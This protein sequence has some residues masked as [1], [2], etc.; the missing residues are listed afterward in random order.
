MK[1]ITDKLILIIFCCIFCGRTT[2]EII[3]ILVATALSALFQYTDSK[4][5]TF[6]AGLLYIIMCTVFPSFALALPPIIYDLYNYKLFPH[7]AIAGGI[8]VFILASD[9][10]LIPIPILMIYTI[11]VY[12]AHRTSTF[13]NLFKSYIS[14]VDHSTEVTRH[15]KENNLRL[16]ESKNYEVHLAT[17][18]ERNRIAREIHDNVGHLLSRSILHVQA[19]KL[20]NDENVRKDG[21]NDL[22][23]TLGSAMD[24]IRQSVHNLHDNSLELDYAIREAVEPLYEKGF[25]VEYQCCCSENVPVRVRLSLISIVKESV[26]N[27]IKHS[28]GNRAS[29]IFTEHPAFWQLK[30]EDNGSCSKDI[31]E[32]GIGIFNMRTRIEELGGIFNINSDKNGFRIFISIRKD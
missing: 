15:L 6:A 8:T 3:A 4:K 2:P 24:S 1:K 20:I 27:I 19:L 30:I 23:G 7:I 10:S 26:S 31:H 5:F 32:N 11:A 12:L 18:N 22:A 14:T 17:L 13:E 25:D 16:T 28:S 9:P 21:L 29:I